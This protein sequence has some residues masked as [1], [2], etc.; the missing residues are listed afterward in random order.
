VTAIEDLF[1]LL[2]SRSLNATPDCR[3]ATVLPFK[4][5]HEFRS[6]VEGNTCGTVNNLIL[7]IASWRLIDHM[8]RTK[9]FVMM[10]SGKKG[11][12]EGEVEESDFIYEHIIKKAVTEALGVRHVDISRA[13]DSRKP[14]AINHEI[15]HDIV[16]S[17]ICIVDGTKYNPN[18]WLELGIRYALKKSVTILMT[19]EDGRPPFDTGNYRFIP[20]STR[21]TGA[22]KAIEDLTDAIRS[23]F[24]N[25]DKSDSLVFDAL[26][27]LTIDFGLHE[28]SEKHSIS[29][30]IYWNK[31]EELSKIIFDKIATGKYVPEMFVGITN[32]GGMF[33]DL[34]TME[35]K[36]MAKEVRRVPILTLWADRFSHT[37]FFDN[38]VNRG[39]FEA[40]GKT[41]KAGKTIELLLLDDNV[42]SGYTQ[43][44]AMRFIEKMSSNFKARYI[45]MF[46]RNKERLHDLYTQQSLLWN[47]PAFDFSFNKVQEL[48]N[49]PLLFMP[50]GKEVRLR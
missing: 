26:K 22:F 49:T 3:S 35:L 6:L 32:G 40:I 9:C 37:D 2:C 15:V 41:V 23:G 47:H 1:S 16:T 21:Y 14:G 43:L 29:W 50:Y 20:Y 30:G 45:P 5:S 10:P 11:E 27:D 44:H 8:S 46:S 33:C 25:R 17:D 4:L 7:I 39:M 34:L 24:S 12:Y 31:I 28:K 18:V 19:Q 36:N 13:V 42:A 48:H 38:A